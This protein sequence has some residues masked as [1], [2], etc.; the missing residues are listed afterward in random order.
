[1]RLDIFLLGLI[2]VE[3]LRT[4]MRSPLRS[5]TFHSGGDDS[6]DL[7]FEERIL[8]DNGGLVV[9]LILFDKFLDD[10]HEFGF[11]GL[12][13]FEVFLHDLY[14]HIDGFDSLLFLA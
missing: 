7:I 6:L 12:G 8:F 5:I 13:L 4:V 11:I 10:G 3:I 14:F 9:E 2:V 1:M